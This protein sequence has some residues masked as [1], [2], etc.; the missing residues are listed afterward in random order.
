MSGT[1]QIQ[2]R[3]YLVADAHLDAGTPGGPLPDRSCKVVGIAAWSPET[4]VG[5]RHLLIP[6]SV[7]ISLLGAGS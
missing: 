7:L 6:A 3:G 4:G 1:R 2:G 5:G